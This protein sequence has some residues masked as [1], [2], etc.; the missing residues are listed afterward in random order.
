MRRLAALLRGSRAGLVLLALLLVVSIG[1]P[2]FVA[3]SAEAGPAAGDGPSVGVLSTAAL[4]GLHRVLLA[5]GSIRLGAPALAA[6][7]IDPR[8]DRPAGNAFPAAD[9]PP[10]PAPHGPRA[11]LRI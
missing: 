8:L 10:A 5:D 4:G 6:L 9:F 3:L 7:L 2:A 11:P 1:V